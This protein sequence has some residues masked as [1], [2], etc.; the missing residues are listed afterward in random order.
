MVSRDYLCERQRTLIRLLCHVEVIIGKRPFDGCEHPGEVIMAL[1]RGEYP[2]EQLS[3]SPLGDSLRPLF[4]RCWDPNPD[5]R[6]GISDVS[7][8]LACLSKERQN[9][10]CFRSNPSHSSLSGPS[11]GKQNSGCICSVWLALRSFHVGG[12]ELEHDNEVEGPILPRALGALSNLYRSTG[13]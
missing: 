12:Q 8:T 3:D 1:N 10:S 11:I 7:R 5:K 6:P 2:A 9:L 13:F 4:L